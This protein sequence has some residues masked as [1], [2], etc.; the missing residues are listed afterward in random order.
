MSVENLKSGTT[1]FDFE[2][3]A[4]QERSKLL[5]STI[6]PRPIAWIVTMDGAGRLN[7]APFSFVN[8]FS[9]DPPVVGVGIGSY[10]CGRPKDTR[11]NIHQTREFVVNLVSEEMAET[12]NVT[13]INFEPGVNELDK[14]EL[15]V[16]VT[17]VGR[18]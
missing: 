6:V 8:A 18:F 2:G 1:C 11:R 4:P 3:L 15:V 7:A 12:M 17:S 9:T 16:P 10:E 13:A 5:L 14:A